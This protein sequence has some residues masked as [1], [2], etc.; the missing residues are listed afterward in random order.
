MRLLSGIT[1]ILPPDGDVVLAF[2]NGRRRKVF[3]RV[4]KVILSRQSPVYAGLFSLTY[5]K[6]INEEHSGLPQTDKA[7]DIV[8]AQRSRRGSHFRV[9]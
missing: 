3:Y 1:L 8:T 7:E 5:I 2:F 4:D 9:Q 6:S